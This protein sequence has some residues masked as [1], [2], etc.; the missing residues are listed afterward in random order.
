MHRAG[1]PRMGR[2][3]LRPMAAEALIGR[4][5]VDH[6]REE[7]SRVVLEAAW[8]LTDSKLDRK[9][10][11]VARPVADVPRLVLGALG[12]VHAYAAVIDLDV[13]DM[14]VLQGVTP[15]AQ[16][17]V[18][19]VRVHVLSEKMAGLVQKPGRAELVDLARVLLL[20]N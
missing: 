17:D 19:H 20:P 12:G 10:R 2:Y 7:R 13:R 11:P 4:G 8:F 5:Y 14:R 1:V 6:V 18:E 9:G 16:R 3:V 15:V